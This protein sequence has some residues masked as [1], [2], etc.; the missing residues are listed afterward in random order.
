MEKTEDPP[1]RPAGSRQWL[2]GLALLA[3]LAGCE[4]KRTVSPTAS[5]PS[6]DASSSKER[7]DAVKEAGEKFGAKP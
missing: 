6:L 7:L 4:A 1:N 2:P 5:R 3:V